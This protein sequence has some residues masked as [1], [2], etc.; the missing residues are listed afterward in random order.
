MHVIQAKSIL[1]NHNGMN[2]Y[3]G[4]TH[5]CIYCD[6]RSIC[7]GFTHAFE[8][9]EVKANAPELLETALR[10]KRKKC[11]I[12]TGSMCDPYLPLEE[13]LLLTRKC[14]AVIDKYGFGATLI[15]KSNL[16]LR[17]LDLLESINRQSKAVVQM[18][19]TT[20]DEDLC[21]MIEPNVCT[22]QERFAALMTLKEAGIPTVVWL[23]PILPFLNDT[24]DN[25]Q[26]IL[27]LCV[28]AEVKGILCFGMGVT[29]RE[30]NREYYYAQLDRLFP[31]LKQ[32]YVETYGN[33]YNLAS[34][35]EKELMLLFRNTCKKSGILYKV[36]D[37]FS[38]LNAF[39]QKY[40]QEE[41]F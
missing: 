19:L 32:R 5:G 34:P 39:P 4:C 30:G 26:G 33:A 7:Y 24:V 41:L 38:Y 17:D 8:D 13:K 27:D 16:V 29:L 35:H 12:G 15:T 25:I 28:N 1:S 14:L 22:T 10:S 18:T 11:M 36:D 3:R 6:T 31:G 37:V 40:V 2:L 21:R 23:S 20:I 9:V